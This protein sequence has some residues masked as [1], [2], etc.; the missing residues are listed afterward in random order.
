[1]RYIDEKW[2]Y[3]V[4]VSDGLPV[5]DDLDGAVQLVLVLDP[6]LVRLEGV[7]TTS[8]CRRLLRLHLDCVAESKQ[9]VDQNFLRGHRQ[10]I[11]SGKTERTHVGLLPEKLG[12]DGEEDDAVFRYEEPRPRVVPIAHGYV[13]R[14][15]RLL[16]PVALLVEQVLESHGRGD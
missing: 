12:K 14:K 16:L 13:R 6:P 15:R 7:A 4:R 5:L 11:V 3:D 9:D 1:M 8:I 2:T 10:C